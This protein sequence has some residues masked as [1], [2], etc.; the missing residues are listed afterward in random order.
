MREK[1][2]DR[3]DGFYGMIILSGIRK[4]FGFDCPAEWAGLMQER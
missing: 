4:G 3:G 2:W 1:W